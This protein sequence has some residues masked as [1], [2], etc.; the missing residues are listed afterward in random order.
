MANFINEHTAW[1]LVRLISPG[2]VRPEAPLRVSAPTGA[3]IW[4][5]VDANGAWQTSTP[6]MDQAREVF[7]LYLPLQVCDHLVIAQM[8]QSLDGRIATVA[9]HSQFMTGPADICRLHRLRALVDAVIV[10][11]GTVASDDPQLTVR[12]AEGENPVRVVLDPNDRLD[13]ASRVFTDGAAPTIVLR[14]AINGHEPRSSLKDVVELPVIGPEGF[15]P[16]S[17]LSLLRERGLNRV[18]VEGGGI[19]VSRFLQA[20]VLDRLH[21][22]V[23]PVLLGSGCPGLKLDPIETLDQALRPPARRFNLGDDVVFDLELS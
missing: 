9:G 8:G 19:T 20:G 21:V 3:D 4:L 11:A 23:A 14:Q 1:N 10:G 2:P 12:E 15:D 17:V 18:L 6:P 16:R 13:P 5:E 7:E 22:T